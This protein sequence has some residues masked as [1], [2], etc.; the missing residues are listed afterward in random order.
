MRV[1]LTLCFRADVELKELY[2]YLF[3]KYI[4]FVPKWTTHNKKAV[5]WDAK[6]H[7]PLLNTCDQDEMLSFGLGD[8]MFY[9]AVIDK[10]HPYRIIRIV[11]DSDSFLPT[12]PDISH[13][14]NRDGFIAGYLYNEDYEFVQSTVYDS[15]YQD[16]VFLPEIL[17]SIKNTPSDIVFGNI[18]KFNTKFNPG[19]SIVMDY[20]SL[21]IGWKMWFGDTFFRFVPKEKI[22]S[23]PHAVYLEELSDN[24][25]YTQLYDKIE[26]PY[27]PDAVFKQ[28]KWREWLD[29][30]GLEEK[31]A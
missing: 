19:R 31:C 1:E 29:Y 28:W 3:D 21:Q 7:Y 8:G 4:T 11:E 9:Y 20:L 18:K 17:A 2:R 22:M 23:F 6:K 13:V 27:T 24:L 26:E 16:R 10:G 25:V 12:T 30:D 15:N 14:A 5:R